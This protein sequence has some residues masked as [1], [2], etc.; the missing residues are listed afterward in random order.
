MRI[1][2]GALLLLVT[3]TGG[4]ATDPADPTD[5]T[6]P[7]DPPVE[8][9]W[10]CASQTH[11]TDSGKVTSQTYQWDE[12]HNLVLKRDAS[13]EVF[14]WRF[15]PSGTI[16]IEEMHEWHEEADTIRDTTR[17]EV[18][19]GRVV[20]E[21]A[22]RSVNGSESLLTTTFRYEAGRL[23]EKHMVGDHSVDVLTTVWYQAP[24]T[25]SEEDDVRSGPFRDGRFRVWKGEPWREFHN[26][27]GVEMVVTRDLDA[28]GREL[29]VKRFSPNALVADEVVDIERSANGA[30]VR[31]VW[32][33][34]DG[35]SRTVTY[36]T[37]CP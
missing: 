20:K 8:N 3:A 37:S 10:P 16:A 35:K 19:E 6:D 1:L 29:H 34:Q 26:I 12:H 23:V 36:Q 17:R 28:Q 7:S 30:P 13:G 2:A 31:E 11:W 25:R 14:T 5:P 27:D 22:T 9:A 33:R 15:D 24:D 32:V 4:C 18:V 21:L